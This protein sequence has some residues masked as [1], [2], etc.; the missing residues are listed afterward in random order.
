M[1]TMSKHDPLCHYHSGW[2]WSAFQFQRAVSPV[3]DG[4]CSTL[5]KENETWRVYGRAVLFE[6]SF[7]FFSNWLAETW[8]GRL[9]NDPQGLALTP[10]AISICSTTLM[11]EKLFPTLFVCSIRADS[12]VSV[13]E[14]LHTLFSSV[15]I[16]IAF[17]ISDG[18]FV[19]L[20]L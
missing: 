14:C 19:F 11:L 13:V 5:R 9:L 16:A 4:A 6:K 20:F 1:P 12:V 2:R 8:T 3:H 7:L 15:F 18:D 10:F 17:E